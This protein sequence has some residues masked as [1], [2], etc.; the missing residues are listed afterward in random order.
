MDGQNESS[1]GTSF[2]SLPPEIRLMIYEL[3]PV[4]TSPSPAKCLDESTDLR[5]TRPS[6]LLATNR[7]CKQMYEDTKTM[8]YQGFVLISTSN[9]S[10]VQ[11][12]P[13][14]KDDTWSLLLRFQRVHFAV[15]VLEFGQRT[16][17]EHVVKSA[18]KVAEVLSQSS[19]LRQFSFGLRCE[20]KLAGFKAKK[21]F[22]RR[23]TTRDGSKAG[24]NAVERELDFAAKAIELLSE[25][26]G[27]RF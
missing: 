16:A 20:L 23:T 13:F 11:S 2:L 7:V 22:L 5:G 14:L 3:I 4:D 18:R 26:T 1:A 6:H 24:L 10:S 27:A 19:R 8:L 25:E 15:E 12:K 9:L 17:I 21:D